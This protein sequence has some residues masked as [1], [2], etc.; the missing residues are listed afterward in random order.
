M[1]RTPRF[2]PVYA[3]IYVLLVYMGGIDGLRR[4]N[5]EGIVRK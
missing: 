1:P 4:G 3:G 2:I 5:S